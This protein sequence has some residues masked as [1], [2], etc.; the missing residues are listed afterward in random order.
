MENNSKQEKIYALQK[1]IEYLK[2]NANDPIIESTY[3]NVESI[4]QEC[5][6]V[7]FKDSIIGPISKY[8]QSKDKKWFKPVSIILKKVVDNF[9]VFNNEDKLILINIFK[10][11]NLNYSILQ[12]SSKNKI[13]NLHINNNYQTVLDDLDIKDDYRADD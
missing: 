9:I 2:K 13:K 10:K 5:K 12:V 8:V 11:L 6:N 3:R 1:Q 4:E 7:N